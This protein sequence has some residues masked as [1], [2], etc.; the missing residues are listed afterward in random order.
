MRAMSGRA[1]FAASRCA[2]CHSARS[3]PVRAGSTGAQRCGEGVVDGV[4]AQVV[5]DGHAFHRRAFAHR[6][7]VAVDFDIQRQRGARTAR[8][9]R[10]RADHGIG[11]HRDLAPRHV[12]GRQPR[13][14]D[15]VEC[16][17]ARN[18]ER[19][20]RDVDA[21]LVMAVA[22]RPHG[23]RVV[24]LGGRRVVDRERGDVGERQLAWR[25]QRRIGRKV[26]S[27]RKR[28]QAERVEMVIVRRRDRAAGGQQRQRIGARGLARGRER[29]PFER[30]LVRPIEQH[31]APRRQC[32]GKPA[33]EQRIAPGVDLP[34]F[35]RLALDR[36]QRRLQ[37]VRR[38]LAVAAAPLLV[39]IHRRRVQQARHRRLLGDARA[40]AE[41]V[42]REHREVEFAVVARLPQEIDVERG[43]ERLRLLERIVRRRRCEAQ[44][45]ARRLDLGALAARGFHLQRGVVVGED[46]AGLQLAV[47]LVQDI[48]RWDPIGATASGG[49]RAAATVRSVEALRGGE[50]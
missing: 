10:E 38:R 17:A 28:R 32:I 21:D 29:L 4:E 46:G 45:H 49:G 36:G 30:I 11:Q 26:E 14:G 13:A 31:L 6:H 41:V 33:G 34:R 20:R 43:G 24:D 35:A 5:D 9:E 12:D 48:H 18:R 37:R 44:Q 16:A 15:R 39:E 1:R 19:G 2:S 50:L 47:V 23:E 27:L 7:A 22:E 3:S 25:R 8:G 40:R 42:A